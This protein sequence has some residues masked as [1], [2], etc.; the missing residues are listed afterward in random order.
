MTG[1]LVVLG[2]VV[3]AVGLL[4]SIALHELGHLSFAKLFKV[5]T[6]QYM[7]GFGPTLWSRRR[8]ETEYGIKAIPLGGYIRMVGMFPPGK[9]ED[10]A[11]LRRASTSPW[12]AMAEDVR[13]AMY[14][15]VKDEDQ[16]RVFYRKPWW[17]KVIIML[18]GPAANLLI[19]TVCF[20]VLLMG[21]GVQ[22]LTPRVGEVSACAPRNYAER[23]IEAAR[24]T[25]GITDSAE[26]RAIAEQILGCR[27]EDP[28]APAAAAG[29]QPGDRIVEFA[30][31][32]VE[33][34]E[35]VQQAIR[36]APVAAV[37]IV[38]LRE[39]QRVPLR[40]ELVERER[41]ALDAVLTGDGSVPTESVRFLG[42][43]PTIE[44]VRQ[45][46]TDVPGQV[47]GFVG[48]VAQAVVA[49]PSKVP[50]IVEAIAGGERARD[51]PV[52]IV[53][54]GRI[55]ADIAVA[56][57]IPRNQ[58]LA[59]FVS[60]LASLNMSLFLFNLMPLLPLDGGHIA[61]ALYEQ[62][63]RVAAWLR[64]RPDPGPFDTARL[65]PA[66]YLFASVLIVFTVLVLVADIVNPVRLPT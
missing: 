9:G 40:A 49:I 37:D 51:S 14:E 55:S 22:Q 32:P 33:E 50:G 34:W 11:H 1:L 10:E 6:T 46:V 8:G 45:P 52:G 59:Y 60:L 16:G 19:A 41:V 53:G 7:V 58:Q 13:T 61:G 18:A 12:G 57:D 36:A 25:Q 23:E 17:Q 21:F 39:G 24:A 54:A 20:A 31:Q 5:K 56:E 4:A 42:V 62:A 28:P 63:R 64:R 30:G 47:V 66:A 65:M 38:V 15:E 3:F 48:T 26:A 35:D 29:L 44:V 43:S 27:A 2:L